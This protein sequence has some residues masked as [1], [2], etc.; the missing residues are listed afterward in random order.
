[1]TGL[2]KRVTAGFMSIVG[3]LIL[4]GAVSYI[5]LSTLSDETDSILNAN[6]HNRELADNMRSALQSHNNA[7]VQMT[8][9]A[10]KEYDSICINSLNQLNRT[11]YTARSETKTK[12]VIDSMIATSALLREVSNQYITE[13]NQTFERVRRGELFETTDSMATLMPQRSAADYYADYLPI[14]NKMATSIDQFVTL[15]QNEL[16]PRT[17]QLHN[18]AYRAVTPV[19]ISLSVMIIIVLMLFYFML[20][21]CVNPIIVITKALQ[22]YISFKIPYAPKGTHRDELAQLNQLI[23]EVITENTELKRSNSNNNLDS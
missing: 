19:L 17:E 22:S 16:A 6:R 23:D 18:N 10:N 8:A 14:H 12:E 3:V 21:S 13:V 20:I 4:A 2:R 11:L 5:E 7:F 1:M 9:F 15:A